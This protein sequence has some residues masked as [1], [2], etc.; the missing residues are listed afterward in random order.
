MWEKFG[1]E[2]KGQ[3]K[4]EQLKVICSTNLKLM[5]EFIITSIKS[6]LSLDVLPAN[7]DACYHFL[8]W[9]VATLELRKRDRIPLNILF[10]KMKGTFQPTCTMKNIS[11]PPKIL[12]RHGFLSK[13]FR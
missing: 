4:D 13:Y 1:H 5:P 10:N 3:Y 11:S 6:T 7:K 2:V 12:W 8:G 9:D